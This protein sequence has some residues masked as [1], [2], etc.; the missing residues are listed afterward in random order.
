MLFSLNFGSR[1]NWIFRQ[2]P[3]GKIQQ[4]IAQDT[5]RSSYEVEAGSPAT[6]S[7]IGSSHSKSSLDLGFIMRTNPQKGR[8]KTKSKAV[9]GI[10]KASKFSAC[11]PFPLAFW[12]PSLSSVGRR[13]QQTAARDQIQEVAPCSKPDVWQQNVDEEAERKGAGK[14]NLEQLEERNRAVCPMPMTEEAKDKNSLKLSSDTR[15]SLHALLG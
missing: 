10:R 3:G 11:P 14:D 15:K 7:C 4:G 8:K 6:S 9:E 1:L 13:W 12:I 5:E 2:H